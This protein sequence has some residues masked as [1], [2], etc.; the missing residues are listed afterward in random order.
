MSTSAVVEKVKKERT[1]RSAKEKCQAVL[2][3]WTGR[4]RPSEVCRELGVPANLLNGWQAR[5]MEGMLAALEPRTRRQ[6]DRGP[7]LDPKMEKLLEQRMVRL[8]SRITRLGA[9]GRTGSAK[10]PVGS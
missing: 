1:V 5:A 3:V 4:R 2:A 10:P 8:E 9:R 6:E 7:L